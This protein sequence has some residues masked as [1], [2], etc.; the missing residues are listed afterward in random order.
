MFIAETVTR[1]EE[2]ITD[3]TQNGTMEKSLLSDL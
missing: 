3:A 2:E 1:V